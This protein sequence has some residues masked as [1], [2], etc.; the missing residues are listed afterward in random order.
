MMYMGHALTKSHISIE[1]DSIE[2]LNP[3]NAARLSIIVSSI[4]MPMLHFARKTLLAS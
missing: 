3:S 4:L 2:V 1:D